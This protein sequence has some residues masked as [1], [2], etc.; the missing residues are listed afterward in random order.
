M[1]VL[2]TVVP[3]ALVLASL[4]H[5]RATQASVVGMTEPVIAAAIAYVLLGEALTPVQMLGGAVVLAGVL[6]A[7]TSR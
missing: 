5:L 3:F 1:V 6:L 2:G 7:E 4:R